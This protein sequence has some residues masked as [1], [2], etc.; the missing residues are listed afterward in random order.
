MIK[1]NARFYENFHILLWLVKDS[2]WLLEWR[3]A[4]TLMIIP[5][6]FVAILIAYK[7]VK[8]LEFYLN[9][10]VC[11]W[12][13]S[14]AFWMLCEFYKWEDYKINAIFPFLIGIGFTT[15]YFYKKNKEN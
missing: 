12:I 14:N 6:I 1:R 2:F 11:C 4:G 3:L 5:T 8:E 7:T 13:F 10:A 9:V 15:I